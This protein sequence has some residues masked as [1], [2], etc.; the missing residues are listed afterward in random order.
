MDAHHL[1]MLILGSLFIAGCQSGGNTA[2]MERE[3][4]LQEDRIYYLEDELA[5][6]SEAMQC[7]Q[8]EL[9]ALRNGPSPAL[10]SAPARH[11][12][13]SPPAATDTMPKV[14][15]ELPDE[16]APLNSLPSLFEPSSPASE[17]SQGT[18]MRIVRPSSAAAAATV[19][20]TPPAAEGGETSAPPRMRFASTLEN[21]GEKTS[22]RVVM[23]WSAAGG[24][25]ESPE[26]ASAA[27]RTAVSTDTVPRRPQWSPYR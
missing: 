4:R 26:A 25:R 17:D 16:P 1:A 14:E 10:S 8:S 27:T 12:T 2:L 24:D 20:S 13:A 11:T 23:Q 15:L 3:L 22:P 5:R 18:A 7:A 6:C 19:R 21:S 9:A